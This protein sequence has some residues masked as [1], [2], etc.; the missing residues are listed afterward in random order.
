MSTRRKQNLNPLPILNTSMAEMRRKANGRILD[1]ATLDLGS[2]FF[3]L[4]D[5]RAEERDSR[6]EFVHC[7]F[8]EGVVGCFF[9]FGVRFAECWDGFEEDYGSEAFAEGS[10][11]HAF[12]FEEPPAIDLSV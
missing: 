9:C 7:G 4:F 8:V 10:V 11:L 2:E 6:A 3:S 1:H 5:A 12:L